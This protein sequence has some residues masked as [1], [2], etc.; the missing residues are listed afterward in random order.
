MPLQQFYNTFEHIHSKYVN[1]HVNLTTI[2]AS[3]FNGTHTSNINN[4]DISSMLFIIFEIAKVLR[5]IVGTSYKNE[6]SIYAE[7]I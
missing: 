7:L 4:Q 1:G 6:R 5:I 2:F 3:N